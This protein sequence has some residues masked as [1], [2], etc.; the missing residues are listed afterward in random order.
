MK[1]ADFIYNNIKQ[2]LIKIGHDEAK[3]ASTAEQAKNKYL[4]GSNWAM[5]KVY[6]TL[7]KDAKKAAGK[8]KPKKNRK[9]G[10]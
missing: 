2:E 9:G 4:S 1:Q 6:E 8:V 7:L 3:A 5:G 10:L